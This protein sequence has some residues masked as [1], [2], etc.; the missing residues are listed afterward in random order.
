M[1]TFNQTQTSAITTLFPSRCR[2]LCHWILGCCLL[3]ASLGAA[4]GSLQAT[5]DRNSISP[6]ETFRLTL[7]YD[8]QVMMDAP[9]FSQLQQDFDIL[10]TQR[11]NQFRSINGQNESWTQWVLT[12]AP[13]HEGTL[14]IPSFELKG[15]FS[16][17]IEIKVQP[18]SGKTPSSS[19][20]VFMQTELQ[21]ETA[22]V[23]Q[24][25]LYTIR[26]FTRVPLT[27]LNRSELKIDNVQLK[28]V[29]ETQ[30]RKT[31][32]GVDYGVVEIVYALFPQQSG[33][34]NIPATLWEVTAPDHSNRTYDPFGR[35]SGKRL[36]LRTSPS[37][38]EVKPKPD[39]YNGYVWLPADALQLSEE[40]SGN[41][42]RMKAGEPITRRLVLQGTG[43]LAAQLPPLQPG[44]V[45]GLRYYPDQPQS[46]ESLGTS[47]VSTRKVESYAIVASKPGRYTLPPVVL[48]WWD[49]GSGRQRQ[50]TL[51]AR[52]I[53]V[54]AA[55]AARLP[56]T[57]TP[58]AVTAL[59]AEEHSSADS[60]LPEAG[61]PSAHNRSWFYSTLALAFLCLVL[62]M[63][64]LRARRQLR[65][66]QPQKTSPYDQLSRS[67]ADAFKALRIASGKDD[68]QALRQALQQWAQIW[69][70][71]QQQQRP[72]AQRQ[73]MAALPGLCLQ[74]PPLAQSLQQLDA[75]LYGGHGSA[76]FDGKQLMEAVI[77]LRQGNSGTPADE[78]LPPLYRSH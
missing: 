8:S 24:Q 1:T 77:A 10:N 34:I 13:R 25:V 12:L 7:R 42:E 16:E 3:L 58:E 39:S 4:A 68:L 18:G 23:Q 29:E 28:Q 52:E 20:E 14:L 60:N 17:A 74:S 49:N 19:Q 70:R 57:A 71:E 47:G 36:R 27:G 37:T 63:Q 46:E 6:E 66:L 41:P 78:P 73:A 72:V 26:L 15:A 43:V 62:G 40:W 35:S 69:W 56:A 33:S 50:L 11:S 67:D 54:G 32:G 65:A 9:E 53:E 76:D 64:W 21:P 22:Y 55:S 44:D 38:L 30:Y 5:V 51:P 45:D 2:T 61:R 48:S 31:V 59:P 75:A